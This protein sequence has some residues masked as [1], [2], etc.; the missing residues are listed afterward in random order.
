M[1]NKSFLAFF[2][3][4]HIVYSS[5][6]I[7]EEYTFVNASHLYSLYF[8]DAS[9]ASDTITNR[10]DDYLDDCSLWSLT[11]L[12]TEGYCRKACLAHV[13][14]LAYRMLDGKYTS[15]LFLSILKVPYCVFNNTN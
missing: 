11:E 8:L 4:I 13:S 14:C 1:K 2:L 10:I 7:N 9:N 5:S 3:F 12:K 15:I 6:C